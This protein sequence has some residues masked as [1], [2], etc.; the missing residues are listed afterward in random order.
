MRWLARSPDKTLLVDV[1][2]PMDVLS[3]VLQACSFWL[4]TRGISLGA[5]HSA[6]PDEASDAT[7]HALPAVSCIYVSAV[8][9]VGAIV[10]LKSS[11]GRLTAV[12]H[13]LSVAVQ[14]L[15]VVARRVPDAHRIL[16][17]HLGE[18][19]GLRSAHWRQGT[20]VDV[21]SAWTASCHSSIHA[22]RACAWAIPVEMVSDATRVQVAVLLVVVVSMRLAA[23]P[24]ATRPA[25]RPTA[26]SSTRFEVSVSCHQPRARKHLL[27][28]QIESQVVVLAALALLRSDFLVLWLG[29]GVRLELLLLDHDLVVARRRRQL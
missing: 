17:G 18:S 4:A 26:Q 11:N 13:P 29:V 5:H 25:H 8:K 1:S 20:V 2:E 7:D 10:A 3:L 27:Q 22:A 12:L 16:L 24:E 9:L 28:V 23:D 15:V 6:D 14:G 19:S 21:A